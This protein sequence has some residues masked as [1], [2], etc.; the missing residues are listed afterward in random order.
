[1]TVHADA[2]AKVIKDLLEEPDA[3]LEKDVEALQAAMAQIDPMTGAISGAQPPIARLRAY[4]AGLAR[5]IKGISTFEGD[6]AKQ[7]ALSGLKQM[8]AGLGVLASVIAQNAAAGAE[9]E[10]EKGVRQLQ[11]ASQSLEQAARS[12]D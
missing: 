3:N 2:G 10:L 8:D 12:I 1:M 5:R 11:K 7:Q 9:K 4:Y 6:G